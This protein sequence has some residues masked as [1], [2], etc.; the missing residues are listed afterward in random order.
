[1]GE[2][3]SENLSQMELSRMS[4]KVIGSKTP[5]DHQSHNLKTQKWRIVLARQNLLLQKGSQAHGHSK[6]KE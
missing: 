6:H 2:E 5:E 4:P 3:A 1:L